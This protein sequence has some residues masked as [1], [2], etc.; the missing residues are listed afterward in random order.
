MFQ[1]QITTNKETCDKK[2]IDKE[3]SCETTDFK[4]GQREPMMEMEIQTSIEDPREVDKLEKHCQ[5]LQSKLS[6]VQIKIL[7]IIN[8]KKSCDE[9]NSTLKEKIKMLTNS[10]C[11]KSPINFNDNISWESSHS[12][13]QTEKTIMNKERNEIKNNYN[14]SIPVVEVSTVTKSSDEQSSCNST[15]SGP[16]TNNYLL[17]KQTDCNN[18]KDDDMKDNKLNFS[19][20]SQFAFEITNNLND[21][22][23]DHKDL[24][25]LETK[26]L[27]P[28]CLRS[29]EQSDMVGACN[30]NDDDVKEEND[31]TSKGDQNLYSL[32]NENKDLKEKCNNLESCLEMMRVEYEKCEDYWQNKLDEERRIYDQ[33]SQRNFLSHYISL[34]PCI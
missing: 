7:E 4:F 20:L 30:D 17:F 29:D 14:C 18:T 12:V 16:S 9:E 2:L 13:Q 19:S 15:V 26:S 8:D 33:V 10:F 5:E 25:V 31:Q 28:L 34:L 1:R 21:S 11:N 32:M 23:L 22:D 6:E 3:T 27:S 24:S